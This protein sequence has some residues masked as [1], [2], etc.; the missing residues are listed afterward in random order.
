MLDFEEI[1][2]AA[3]DGIFDKIGKE[4]MLITAKGKT[5][6][7]K[8]AVNTMTAS[9]GGC[10]I[11]WNRPV[12]FVFVRPQRFTF[13]LLETSDAFSLSFLPEEKREALRI[14]G[15]LSGKNT[16]KWSAAGLTPAKK[17]G[18]PFVGEA[19]EVLFCR[20][21]YAAPLRKEAFLVPELLDNYRANDFHQMYVAEITSAM[22]RKS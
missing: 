2:P 12:A 18:V 15:T 4:W 16:D 19:K 20:K 21:L 6:D 8:E 9:W 5:K 22:K 14:C 10:G 3:F 1:A 13:P 11:L 7:G 17:E